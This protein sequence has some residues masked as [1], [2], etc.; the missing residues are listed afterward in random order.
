[1][2]VSQT[3]LFGKQKKKLFTNQINELDKAIK[4]IITNPDL[5]ELKK[6]DLQGIRVYKFRM[7]NQEYLLAY[8]TSKTNLSLV[9]MGTHENFYR[10]LK[11]SL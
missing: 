4:K 10:D 5:G 7:I 6:G 11:K 9:N 1:L 3:T 8:I 2:N